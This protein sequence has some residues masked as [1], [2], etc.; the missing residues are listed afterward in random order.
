MRGKKYSLSARLRQ[1]FDYLVMKVYSV[2]YRRDQ[3]FHINTSLLKVG[4]VLLQQITDICQNK[5]ISHLDML[6]HNPVKAAT[7]RD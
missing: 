5:I 1:T 4:T 2:V 7:E 3:M 6:H